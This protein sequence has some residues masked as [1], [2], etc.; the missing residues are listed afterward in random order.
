MNDHLYITRLFLNVN[1]TKKDWFVQVIIALSGLL[2]IIPMHINRKKRRKANLL[3][4]SSRHRL[5]N[6]WPHFVRIGSF[7]GNWQI[8]H[9]NSSSTSFTNSSSYPPSNE[10]AL[11]SA[12]SVFRRQ[13]TGCCVSRVDKVHSI[14]SRTS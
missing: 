1:E 4:C 12:I 3:K 7:N 13:T 2:N 10:L 9:C 5:Q 8:A 11:A 14:L 6:L